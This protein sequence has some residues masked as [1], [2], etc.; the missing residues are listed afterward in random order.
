MFY[1][2]RTHSSKSGESLALRARL[3]GSLPHV[4]GG[5]CFGGA[6]IER[7]LPKKDDGPGPPDAWRT[8][9]NCRTPLSGAPDPRTQEM[10]RGQYMTHTQPS[11]NLSQFIT[12]C[13]FVSNQ[14]EAKK[15]PGLGRPKPAGSRALHH[16]QGTEK[17]RWVTQ[18]PG[19]PVPWSRPLCAP[20][21]HI[22]PAQGD[23]RNI[24]LC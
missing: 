22:R 1:V 10:G 6:G 5:Y 3:K 14:S 4:A 21:L 8:C 20:V 7:S 2:F 16:T 24:L 15:Q 18:S 12:C 11:R 9:L 17:P 13:L 19:C 23:L